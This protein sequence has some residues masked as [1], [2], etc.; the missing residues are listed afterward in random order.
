VVLQG[1]TMARE[2][3]LLLLFR[4]GNRTTLK[5][6]VLPLDVATQTLR[7]WWASRLSV[8]GPA[9]HTHPKPGAHH[10]AVDSPIT[11]SALALEH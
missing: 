5:A 1:L 9:L 4:G 11:H 10:V 8:L 3:A 6:L 2:A 7:H